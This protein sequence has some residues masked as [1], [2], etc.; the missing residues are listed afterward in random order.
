MNKL[1]KSAWINLAVSTI[2]LPIAIILMYVM[3][4]SNAKGIRYIL[5]FFIG[6]SLTSLTLF[7]I[8]RKKGPE[9]G[10]DE[11]EKEIYKRA[12]IWSAYALAVFLACVCFVP[13]F[14]LGG[15]SNVPVFYLPVIFCCTL[16]FAQFVHSATVL[17]QCQL[18]AED[19]R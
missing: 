4:R 9:A 17:I 15:G 10:F 7:L 14:A 16:F 2:C 13:F 3:A 18:E 5:I 8:F 19:E 12:F 1:Q 11:R 6:G